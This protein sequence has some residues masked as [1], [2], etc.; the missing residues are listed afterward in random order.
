MT[1]Y[2]VESILTT[3]CGFGTYDTIVILPEN[4][5]TLL[6][7]GLR[8]A[9]GAR[10]IVGTPGLLNRNVPMHVSRSLRNEDNDLGD[11]VQSTA[12]YTRILHQQTTIYGTHRAE[13]RRRYSKGPWGQSD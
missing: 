12:I 2:A 7:M 11:S 5:M 1:L 4:A 6:W 13:T 3:L 9:A 8:L 10:K